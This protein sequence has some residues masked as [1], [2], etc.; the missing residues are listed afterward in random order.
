MLNNYDCDN[1]NKKIEITLRHSPGVPNST[2]LY[3]KTIIQSAITKS[4]GFPTEVPK[5]DFE[6]TSSESNE[7]CSSSHFPIF[8]SAFS[9]PSTLIEQ[10]AIIKN[11][12]RGRPSKS[13]EEP[14]DV[15]QFENATPEKRKYLELRYRNNLACR[16]ARR[17]RKLQEKEIFTEEVNEIQR[18]ER[19]KTELK[20]Y[21]SKQI[22]LI[23]YLEKLIKVSDSENSYENLH[24]FKLY[25]MKAHK[26]IASHLN[27]NNLQGTQHWMS[28]NSPTEIIS[29]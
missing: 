19:L 22:T 14:M 6:E 17:K 18:N 8:H 10:S 7:S 9:N 11:R 1:D 15:E 24:S 28:Q 13:H 20:K 26:V 16:L 3:I 4:N 23:N 5:D 12:G 21:Q 25:K 29:H 27:G 2:L